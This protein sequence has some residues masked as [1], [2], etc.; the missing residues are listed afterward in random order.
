MDLSRYHRTKLPPLGE[1]T[2]FRSIRFDSSVAGPD[3]LSKK[4]SVLPLVEDEEVS[5]YVYE[6]SNR[7]LSTPIRIR[8]ASIAWP[9]SPNSARMRLLAVATDV[10]SFPFS[11]AI[12]PI[13]R[14]GDAKGQLHRLFVA[15][16]T[17]IIQQVL[18]DVAN[19]DAWEID[20][21]ELG[22]Q[23][24]FEVLLIVNTSD[25]ES[26]TSIQFTREATN[27]I[28]GLAVGTDGEGREIFIESKLLYQPK[29]TS[30]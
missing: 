17:S 5:I 2:P 26:L 23:G 3:E 21:I 22:G 10:A 20:S 25:L 27:G 7:T 19:L 4:D 16:S 24:T 30:A 6:I 11:T 28:E 29:T 13:S 1:L 12:G 14:I 15:P 9:N 18:A 8:M